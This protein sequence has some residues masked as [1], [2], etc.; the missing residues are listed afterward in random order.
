MLPLLLS[1]TPP[2]FLAISNPS[3]LA[4]ISK[5]SSAKQSQGEGLQADTP[6]V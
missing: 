4:V 5:S 2:P 6:L 3:K 1:S